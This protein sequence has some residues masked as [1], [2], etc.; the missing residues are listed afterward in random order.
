MRRAL[1][2][3]AV[4]VSITLHGTPALAQQATSGR[5]ERVGIDFDA[6]GGSS[7]IPAD[8]EAAITP[9]NHQTSCSFDA[10]ENYITAKARKRHQ[11]LSEAYHRHDG[12]GSPDGIQQ[13][14]YFSGLGKH[15]KNNAACD[16]ECANCWTCFDVEKRFFVAYVDGNGHK[17]ATQAGYGDYYA[18]QFGVEVLPYVLVDGATSYI[19]WGGTA[20]FQYADYVGNRSVTLFSRES[21]NFLSVQ[22]GKTYSF[23]LGPTVRWDFEIC[24]IRI[25]PNYT[26]GVA[27]DW[28]QMKETAPQGRTFR[29]IDSF[30]FTGFDVGGYSRLMFDFPITDWLTIGTGL[31]YKYSPTDVM[32]D[33]DDVRKHMGFVLQVTHQF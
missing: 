2:W 29:S 17:T 32:V 9:V 21:G 15:G 25:S 12:S 3:L 14:G 6:N 11:P 20:I 23:I 4:L 22:D 28:T 24:G 31:D 33:K 8:P 13:T 10:Y 16:F 30:K 5:Y 19:R 27:F 26:M 7:V 18:G 1:G